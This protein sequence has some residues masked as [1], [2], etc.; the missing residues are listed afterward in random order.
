MKKFL[1]LILGFVVLFSLASCSCSKK[2]EA[3]RVTIDV[4]PSFEL[5]VD[6]ENKVV[7]VT[8]LNDDASVLLYG[9]LIVGKDIEDA[10]EAIINLTIEAG[11]IDGESEQKVSISVSGDGRYQRKLEKAVVKQIDTVLEESGIKA[12]VEKH[13]ALAI[14]NL[15]EIVIENSTY[16]KEEVEVMTEEELLVALKVSRIE[17]AE[18]LSEEMRKLYFETKEYE[19]SFSEREEIAKVIDELGGIYDLVHAGYVKAL[20]AY[21]LAIN[22]VENLKYEMLIASD[23]L[24]QQALVKVLEAK[25]EYLEQKKLVAS[26]ETGDL[27]VEAEIKL[28]NLEKV[29]DASLKALEEVGA[30]ATLAFDTVIKTMKTAEEAFTKIEEMFDDNIKETLQQNAAV[31]ETKLNELKNGFF[32]KFEEEHKDDIDAY[33]ENLKQQK[34]ALKASIE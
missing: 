7:S 34:E 9:E 22:E 16:T 19:I 23:S 24:Y 17:T 1:S 30:A 14:E 2:T 13:E 5:I 32:A 4:N 29:Y 25:T 21:R 20:E 3:S 11:Y 8:A 6:E 31:L 26:L 12:T 28:D 10:T 33:L 27:K 18:L 15:R